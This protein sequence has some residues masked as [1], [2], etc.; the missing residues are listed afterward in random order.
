MII[1]DNLWNDIYG[2][3]CIPDT[4]MPNYA[5][6]GYIYLT[7]N[8][9]TG[10]KYIGKHKR[11]MRCIKRNEP[12]DFYY[13]G[14][15][16]LIKRAI[17]KY[18]INSFI[19]I[20]FEYCN[21]EKELDEK[22]IYWIKHFNAINRKDFYNIAAGGEGGDTMSNNPNKL[23]ITKRNGIK[24][25]IA[26]NREDVKLKKA[27][28]LKGKPSHKKNKPG[29]PHTEEFKSYLSELYKGRIVSEETR[30]KQ[31][32]NNKGVNNP[33]H[34]RMIYKHICLLCIASFIKE[35]PNFEFINKAKK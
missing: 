21:N 30:N 27:L 6:C 32:K 13:I 33:S 31:S 25:K 12:I 23:I 5:Y 20:V 26:Q 16:K 19:N 10:R 22:E 29:T 14:S 28:K 7:Y 11:N 15:G 4:K 1:I 2:N 24:Q 3:L 18:G 35:N 8:I 34:K 17:K 9:I